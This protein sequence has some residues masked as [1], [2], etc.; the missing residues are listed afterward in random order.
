MTKG[1]KLV[2][3]KKA[4]TEIANPTIPTIN[5]TKKAKKAVMPTKAH[6]T[7]AGFD[8]VAVSKT[9]TDDYIEYETGIAVA[10]PKGYAGF[11]FPRSSVSKYDLVLANCVG[12]IDSEYRGTI[13]ARFK[14]TREPWIFKKVKGWLGTTVTIT[15][16]EYK[17]YN[18]GD[19]IAQLI[20]LPIPQFSFTEV[21]DLDSTDRGDGGFG[22]T[23]N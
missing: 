18:A 16:R 17:E 1:K 11:L 6:D 8:L 20:I 23:G 14:R 5:F 12:V 19:K 22:S 4:E 9:V 10:I 21:K 3:P 13:K 7:D 15:D 2:K